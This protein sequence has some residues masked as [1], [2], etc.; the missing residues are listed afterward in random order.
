MK[1]VCD[2]GD[3]GLG[4]EFVLVASGS[5]AN[6]YRADDFFARLDDDA[7]GHQ[8]HA[9]EMLQRAKRRAIAN[10]P[11]DRAGSAFTKV[12]TKR[13]CGVRFAAAAIEEGVR[14]GEVA[15]GDGL[16]ETGRV[17]P[18]RGSSVLLLS[19]SYW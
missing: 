16:N 18:G 5:S 10:P 14:R 2:L 7:T 19:P 4:A 9:R 17:D 3:G 11:N 6:T 8:K 13:D 12:R 1:P 15:F